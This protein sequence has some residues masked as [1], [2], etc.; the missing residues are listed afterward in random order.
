M[1]KL[2]GKI[3]KY[4]SQKRFGFIQTKN[5]KDIFFY[6]RE[7]RPKR[8]PV[9]GEQVVFELGQDKQGRACAVNIQELSFVIQKQKEKTKKVQQKQ[10]YK[11]YQER[12]AQKYGVL[13]AICVFAVIFITFLILSVL[14]FG[15]SKYLLIWYII[16]G[17]AS[18]VIYWYDKNQ[19]QNN[20]WRVSENTLHIIDVLGGW[21]GASFA[22]RLLNHKA[23]KS[24]F[25]GVF[26][27]TIIANIFLGVMIYL[28]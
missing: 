21:V 11:A 10:S 20:D 9:I 27:M 1:H 15:I 16:I 6:I 19:A 26:Y 24:S 12:Q 23:T 4:D 17:L 18:F 3:I 8:T 25:R 13:N 28:V 7:F 2:D 22:H 5:K 14:A